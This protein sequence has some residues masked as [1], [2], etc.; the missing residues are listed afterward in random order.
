MRD[1]SPS[2]PCSRWGRKR[3]DPCSSGDGEDEWSDS[4]HTRGRAQP[5]V[6]PTDS[7]T[8]CCEAAAL[9]FQEPDPNRVLQ[10]PAP[11]RQQRTRTARAADAAN[12]QRGREARRQRGAAHDSDGNDSGAAPGHYSGFS[13]EED[14]LLEQQLLEAQEEGLAQPGTQPS[15]YS[16][17]QQ[18]QHELGVL[19]QPGMT[20]L[21]LDTARLR[22]VG[23]RH[24]ADIT[25]AVVQVR[26]NTDHRFHRCDAAPLLAGAG[27]VDDVGCA[28]VLR[29]DNE[30]AWN[31]ATP[32]DPSIKLT[33]LN[34]VRFFS[35]QCRRSL[36]VPCWH[37]DSCGADFSAAAI[38]VGCWLNT[39][40]AATMWVQEDVLD[41][42]TT[43]G[44]RRG[45]SMTGALVVR[46]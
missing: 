15:Q 16:R 20:A 23:R 7:H 1:H 31:D 40:K 30:R 10:K 28:P 21:W 9:L 36:L 45:L 35:Q 46:A 42:F 32:A 18:E 2:R 41:H 43:L 8:R 25:H 3:P 12:L 14:A 29:R 26:A 6:S 24:L 33:S 34:H 27:H 38:R 19:S 17:D 11:P 5:P 44:A 39:P 13:S 22:H 37:C 4:S